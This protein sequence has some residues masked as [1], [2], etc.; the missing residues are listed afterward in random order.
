MYGLYMRL[1][2]FLCFILTM[3]CLLYKTY[4]QVWCTLLW[5]RLEQPRRN[6]IRILLL[7]L[8]YVYILKK[9][10]IYFHVVQI[11]TTTICTLHGN[12]PQIIYNYINLSWDHWSYFPLKPK[13][14]KDLVSTIGCKRCSPGVWQFGSLGVWEFGSLGVWELQSLRVAERV[15]RASCRRHLMI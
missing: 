9:K 8:K 4:V 10:K 3:F 2:V 13:L 7:T 14:C 12:V 6:Y 11:S 5:W 1:P 15:A